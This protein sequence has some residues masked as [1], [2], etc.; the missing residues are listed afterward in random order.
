MKNR[1]KNLIKTV[2]PDEII[3]NLK[4]IFIDPIITQRM[5]NRSKDIKPFQKQNYPFGLNLIGDIKAET[6][7]GQSMRIIA[8][9]I[10]TSGIPFCILQIESP[11][12]LKHSDSTWNHRIEN[13]AKYSINII[14]INPNIWVESYNN[15][16]D[17]ILNYRYN[18][19]YWLWELEEF[20]DEWV[21]CISTVEEI[22]TPSEFVSQSIRHKTNKP[23]ITVPYYIEINKNNMHSRDYFNL[24]TN[25]FLFLTMYDLKSISERKNPEAVIDA[26]KQ[27]FSESNEEVGLIIK[28]NHINN[29]LKL[30]DL[31]LK[32]NN[33]KNIYY[34]TDN[35]TRNEVESLISVSDVLVSLHRSEGFGLPLAEAMY[36]GTPVIAT[37]WSANTEFMNKEC[38]CLVD[39]QFKLINKDIGYYKKGNRWA[40][41]NVKTAAEYMQ[42][43]F[44]DKNYYK[45][46]KEKAEEYVRIK[47]SLEIIKQKIEERCTIINL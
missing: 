1:V 4:K 28:I 44:K 34:I 33:Y 38:A 11:G 30:N 22:W 14:H 27:A 3:V 29:K 24:P 5:I 12:G 41:A 7:L 25:Q 31:Q 23:V 36:L 45:S 16:S 32:L 18:I 21:P 13:K 42:K 9:A 26:Y 40:D 37:N 6:G 47:L 20:P 8:E 15:L 10:E 2:L 43:L 17:E 39:Y 35:L 19:A 46:K